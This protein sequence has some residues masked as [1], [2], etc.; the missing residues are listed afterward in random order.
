M[1]TIV[2]CPQCQRKLKIAPASIGKSV[3][4]PCGNVFKAQEADEPAAAP[5]T[6]TPAPA[7]ATLVVACDGCQ[8]KLKVPAS[9]RGRKM[10]CSKCGTTF[11][12]PLDDA[13]PARKAAP[14]RPPFFEDAPEDEPRPSRKPAAPKPAFVED[15]D[16]NIEVEEPQPRRGK[17]KT[18]GRA[19]EE[20]AAPRKQPAPASGCVG[21]ILSIFVLFIVL[22]YSAALSALHF[23]PETV[24]EY[25]ELPFG[26][27]PPELGKLRN[28][29]RV[30][31]ADN[32]EN[33]NDAD[34]E[35][36]DADS[37]KDKKDAARDKDKKD[38]HTDAA[39]ENTDKDKAKDKDKVKDKGNNDDGAD[40]DR[41]AANEGEGV[42][43]IPATPPAI[44]PA[45]Q[46]GIGRPAKP[47]SNDRKNQKAASVS[48]PEA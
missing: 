48:E 24:S 44:T 6:P 7:A 32:K 15:D 26:K 30:P 17:G 10:K 19:G 25:V 36:K 46:P 12:V 43:L 34:G 27:P 37:A 4:C 28:A 45:N 8:T 41:D 38:T 39:N 23:Y 5:R 35:K 29:P 3:K 14:T 16:G 11:A 33:N 47:A 20:A 2:S 42:T 13:P 18:P 22:G 40:K 1:P 9:A 21:C 31:D